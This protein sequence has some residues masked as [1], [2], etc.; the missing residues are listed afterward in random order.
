[1][2]FDPVGTENAVVRRVLDPRA[3]DTGRLS[4]GFMFSISDSSQ[5][6]IAVEHRDRPAIKCQVAGCGQQHCVKG[7]LAA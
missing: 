3:N 4:P 7:R 2:S 5:V 1:M 6:P